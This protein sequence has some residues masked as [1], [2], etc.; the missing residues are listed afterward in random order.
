MIQSTF[1]FIVAALV[2][3]LS[4]FAESAIRSNAEPIPVVEL[5]PGTV[6]TLDFPELG[7]M[8]NEESARC[9]VRIP[10]SYTQSGSFPIFVWF[11]G[12]KG[13]FKVEAASR[14]V[15]F[16]QFIVVALPYPDGRFPRLGV[17]DGGIEDFWAFQFPMLERLNA[18]IPNI[19]ETVRIASGSS[20]GGHLLGSS[21]DL[22]WPGFTDY[23]TAFAL[24]EGGYAPH[25]TYTGISEETKV[26]L[27]YGGKSKSKKW[28]ASFMSKFRAA[29]EQTTYIE[30]PEAGHGLN[31]DGKQVIHQW[32]VEEVLPSL[33]SGEGV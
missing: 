1:I 31:N 19:S 22:D 14:M 28:Q 2:L 12:G 7:N 3:Q 33:E 18:M 27:L 25:M 32:I 10:E 17:R 8:A 29:H 21:I 4:S 9:E 20:S 24:H 13:S 15:D 23:F 30:I 26:L 16:D 5:I 11:G 6:L